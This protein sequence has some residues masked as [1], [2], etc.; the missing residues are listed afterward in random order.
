MVSGVASMAS[1][2]SRQGDTCAHADSPTR[3]SPVAPQHTREVVSPERT[4]LVLAT[5]VPYVEL[6]VLVCDGLDVEAD[7]G[8]GGDVLVK[9]ELVEDS[10]GGAVSRVGGQLGV[11]SG[12]A[13][14]YSSFL[15][16]RGP[17]STAASPLIRR[18]WP[19]PWIWTRPLCLSVAVCATSRMRG[20]GGGTAMDQVELQFQPRDR[21]RL[22][23]VYA[24]GE[25]NGTR[26]GVD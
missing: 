15:R 22:A 8:D 9:L 10:C 18:S 23:C 3:N 7:G 13:A 25:L 16:R 26:R 14:T 24:T 17:A 12:T 20:R 6:C 5:D 4:D 1:E 21:V 2:Q 11:G 19:W